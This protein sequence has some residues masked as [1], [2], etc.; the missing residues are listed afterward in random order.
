[1]S[2]YTT[3][4]VLCDK[5]EKKFGNCQLVHIDV[6]NEDGSNVP[7]PRGEWPNLRGF[8]ELQKD[9]TEWL[10]STSI[11][12]AIRAYHR[13]LPT[14]VRR[15]IHIVP[16][17]LVGLFNRKRDVYERAKGG[18]YPR[19][20]RAFSRTE[21]TVWPINIENAHWE[22]AFIRKERV[23]GTVLTGGFGPFRRITQ[24]AIMDS[25]NNASN[26]RR[27]AR[28]DRR[29]PNILSAYGFMFATSYKRNV[30]VPA[31]S[32]SHSCGPRVY[33]E[34]KQ[35]MERVAFLVADGG[36]DESLWNNMDDRWVNIDGVRW[37]MVGITAYEIIRQMDFQARVYRDDTI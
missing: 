33:W 21:Y 29:M 20:F 12:M 18:G 22:L 31:Q 13:T 7:K 1:M 37:E 15:T 2:H 14:N 25:W 10:N 4:Q 36:Y 19:M 24:V 8:L 34:A 35:M 30:S 23:E 11:D 9:P 16:T 3:A 5:N 26:P 28:I 32:D 27:K 17:D 6:V